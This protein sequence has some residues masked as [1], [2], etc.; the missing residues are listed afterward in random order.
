MTSV[1][2]VGSMSIFDGA[3]QA[4][5]TVTSWPAAAV[6]LSDSGYAVVAM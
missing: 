4:T 1:P 3:P 6:V 5:P 2:S